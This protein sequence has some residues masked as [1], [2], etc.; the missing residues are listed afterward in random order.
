MEIKP[1]FK[2]GQT[3]TVPGSKSYSQRA[4]VISAL[5]AG[6]STLWNP[7][8]AE[9]TLF[10]LSALRDMGASFTAGEGQLFVRGTGRGACQPRS[11]DFAGQ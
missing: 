7:L 11:A 1:F 4:M 2:S 6:D 9:D 5:A 8:V 3:V 10:L